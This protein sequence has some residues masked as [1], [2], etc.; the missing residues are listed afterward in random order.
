MRFLV[1]FV[2]IYLSGQSSSPT[3][4]AK[5]FPAPDFVLHDA[6]HKE[7]A[8]GVQ[9]GPSGISIQSGVGTPTSIN[10]LAFSGDGKFLAAGKDFGRV[11]VWNF[12]NRTVLRAVE[13]GQ[14][15]VTAV[16]LNND[17]TILATGGEGD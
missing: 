5:P 4:P 15:A 7:P 1:L 11:V 10:V 14:G 17:G 6:P 16:A 8:S 3:I 13:T 12:I 2:P 9:F